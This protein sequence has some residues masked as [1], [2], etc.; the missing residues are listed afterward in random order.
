VPDLSDPL[1]PGM[2]WDQVEPKEDVKA[3]EEIKS[4]EPSKVVP[5][6]VQEKAL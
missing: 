2:L 6:F 4:G 3:E 5:V 1:V